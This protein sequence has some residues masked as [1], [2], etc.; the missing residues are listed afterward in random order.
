MGGGSL[1]GETVSVTV[2]LNED[3]LPEFANAI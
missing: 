1:R 3:P 2:E